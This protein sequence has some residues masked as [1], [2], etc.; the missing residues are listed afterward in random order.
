[1]GID[2]SKCVR[3]G[4]GQNRVTWKTPSRAA[5]I[6]LQE[7]VAVLT[8]LRSPH[9]NVGMKQYEC[10]HTQPLFHAGHDRGITCVLKPK[11]LRLI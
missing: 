1:V 9:T 4:P 8:I 5:F 6:P 3:R 7:R 2:K 11:G 10:G